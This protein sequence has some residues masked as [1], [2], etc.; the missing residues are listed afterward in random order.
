MC[1]AGEVQAPFSPARRAVSAARSRKERALGARVCLPGGQ[2]GLGGLVPPLPAAG[3]PG[4]TAQ[5]PS[6]EKRGHGRST[7]LVPL[8][9]EEDLKSLLSSDSCLITSGARRRARSPTA[10]IL[11]RAAAAIFPLI[12]A[13]WGRGRQ[14]RRRRRRR[15]QPS[16]GSVSARWCQAQA[17]ASAVA[18][19]RAVE[20][21]PAAAVLS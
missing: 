9:A 6:P 17:E 3:V 15:R 5:N 8:G 18:G 12:A 11:A 10:R 2:G 13:G 16:G 14:L 4:W 1:R 19:A 20:R 7:H 21:M